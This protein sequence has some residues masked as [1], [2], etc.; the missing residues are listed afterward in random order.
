MLVGRHV[1]GRKTQVIL[2][3]AVTPDRLGHVVALE[4]VEQHPVRLVEDVRQDVQTPP[5]R[6]AH[7]DFQ[8]AGRAGPL[9]DRVQERNQ[10]LAPLERKP[11]LAHIVLVEKRLEQLGHVQLVDNP[12]LLLDV[13]RR[14][15]AH[16]LHPLEQPLADL[17]V[18]D[19]HELDA[20]RAAVGLPQDRDQLA[21]GREPALAQLVVKDPV[22]VGFGQPKRR[23]LKMFGRDA[24]GLELERV[25][26]GHIM[27]KLAVSIDQ[28]R[29]GRLAAGRV[30]V[31]ALSPARP[32]D[33]GLT[34]ILQKSYAT[35]RRPSRVVQPA[36]VVVLDQ[37]QVQLVARLSSVP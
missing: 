5:V 36:L 17:G 15:V 26:I 31:D 21:Q 2:D 8:D 28:P 1:I 34:H 33:L 27:A 24:P 22:Q 9:D 13:E 4:L 18:A 37:A 32:G 19:M 30:G 23:R 7:D 29:D 11:L 3:V 14:P 25:E 10:H 12:P 20:D 35:S 6:H 16:R